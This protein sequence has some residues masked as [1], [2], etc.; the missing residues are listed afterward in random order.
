MASAY[1]FPSSSENTAIAAG[2]GL[3]LTHTVAY[4]LDNG[5]IDL[6]LV[7]IT[8]A[9]GDSAATINSRLSTAVSNRASERGYAVAKS[10]ITLPTISKG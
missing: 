10:G 9:A 4:G 2:G 5:T 7:T 8:I 1:V 3:I 6:D